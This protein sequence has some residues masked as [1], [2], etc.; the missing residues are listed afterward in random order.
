VS[1]TALARLYLRRH[2]RLAL[3]L[4]L[5]ATLLLSLLMMTQVLSDSSRYQSLYSPLLVISSL[6]LGGLII[7]IGINISDLFR[8]LRNKRAGARLTVRLVL[9]FALLAISPL[10]IMYYFSLE[11][12]HQRLDNWF[13]TQV[14]QT[15][16]SALKLSRASLSANQRNALQK[17]NKLANQLRAFSDT[18]AAL[19]LDN[20]REQLQMNEVLLLKATGEIIAFSSADMTQLL[21]KGKLSEILP[22]ELKQS[23]QHVSLEPVEENRM[24]IQAVV[25]YT[26]RMNLKSPEN[27]WL[28]ALEPIPGH[29]NNLINDVQERADMYSQSTYLR[30]SLKVSF[31]LVLSLVMLLGLFG[32]TW[33]AFFAARLLVRPIR[34]LAEGTRA[35]ADGDYN[36]QLPYSNLDELG[37]LVQSFNLMTRRIREARDL[38]ERSQHMV[39]AQLAYLEIV[40]ERMS[41]GILSL[42]GE[43]R[44]RTCNA[45]AGRIL[46]VDLNPLMYQ[47]LLSACEGYPSL[48]VL[49]QAAEQHLMKEDGDWQEEAVFFS[50]S[51][52][53]VLN[54]RGTRLP[55]LDETG[56]GHVIVFDDVTRLLQAQREAA[57]SGVARRLAHEIKNPLTP[58][59]LSAERL[60]HKYLPSFPDKEARTLDR[61]THTI[62][63]QVEAMKEM[64]DNFSNYARTPEISLKPLQLNIVLHEVLDLYQSSGA[65]IERCLQADLPNIDADANRLR[66]VFT[67]LVKNALEA[68]SLEN[69]HVHPHVCVISRYETDEHLQFVEIRIRD[70]G[71]G[72]PADMLDQI[73]EPYVTTKV[74]GNGLGLAI[75]KKI[76]EEH[77]GVIWLENNQDTIGCT[78]YIRLPCLPPSLSATETNLTSTTGYLTDNLSPENTL[79]KKGQ[80]LI[81]TS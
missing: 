35:V 64:L 14:N 45:A 33:A 48:Q 28:V 76:I 17:T 77:G 74:K 4:L 7:L 50:S 8:Q 80:L 60:R 41:S 69:S 78:V 40:L 66:Q 44:L 34:N 31:T 61:M 1:F 21:P 24:T 37:F 15:L 43:Y 71:P 20:L 23:Q 59:R 16:D 11:F 53:K 72:I 18:E 67:N 49:C 52:R 22:M 55:S 42:D 65:N 5:F 56:K 38:A 73:F 30:Q 26:P 6:G 70:N 46:G 25:Q 51:G 3:T 47:P 75:V 10:M 32:A 39:D 13:D 27:R 54:C 58:I 12:L 9:L 57:W 62:I 2:I 81:Q 29:L 63:Q 79:S 19:E 68:Q 36:K